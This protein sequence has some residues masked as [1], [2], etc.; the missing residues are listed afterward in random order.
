[1]KK[2]FPRNAWYCAAWSTE[3][4]EDLMHR[5]IIKEDLLLGRD[6]NGSAFALSNFC[7]HRSAPLHLGKFIDNEIECPYH[8]LHFR[9]DGV[10]TMNPHHPERKPAEKACLK[11]YVLVEKD[12]LLWVWMGDPELADSETIPDFS[13][14]VDSEM[15]FVFGLIEI[16]AYYELITDNLMD[17]THA[18]FV[19]EGIL[20]SEA[21]SRGEHEILQ[22]GTTIWSNRWCPDGLAPPSLDHA[23]GK[24]GKPVDHW[25]NM[26]WDAPASMLLDVGITPVGKNRDEGWWVYGTDILTPQDE[27]HTHYYWGISYVQGVDD[28]KVASQ[29][30]KAIDLAF[31]N[32]DK[33]IIEAQQREILLRGGIDI[34][35][36]ESVWLDTDSGPRR[37]RMT[38]D[39]LS[40][41]SSEIVAKP[42]NHELYAL[43][44]K[45]N[46]RDEKDR[47]IPAV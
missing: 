21:I 4:T 7:P 1:M 23:F 36:V 42:A 45:F 5:V 16:D 38:L 15:G 35:D 28:P 47:I 31:V 26:R 30:K 37:A 27:T 34:E 43:K 8:G 40:K 14:H 6:S 12:A 3:V 9:T 17:L 24:Y 25:L 44:E 22:S 19:H 13:C 11:Q 33:P 10:C 2:T 18:E 39:K 20:G 29:H 32:Q 41:S 46:G